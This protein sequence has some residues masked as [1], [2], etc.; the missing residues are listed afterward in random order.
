MSDLEILRYVYGDVDWHER[1]LSRVL[2]AMELARKVT[3]DKNVEA[4]RAKFAERAEV[5]LKKY[6]VT[7][8]RDDIDLV[9]WL[10]HLQ[11]EL[12]DATVY[13]ERVLSDER[14][15]ALSVNN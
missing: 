9:G 2:E 11:E 13:I 1:S 3:V 12:M 5:G 7:T 8:E 6:G 4:V 15:H 10:T 14:A